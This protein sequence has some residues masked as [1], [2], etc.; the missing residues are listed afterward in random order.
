MN[1]SE[2][3]RIEH[4]INDECKLKLHMLRKDN[5]E[6]NRKFNVG[7]YVFNVTG[8]IKVEKIGYDIFLDN[9]EIIYY[10][11][12][13]KNIKGELTR[14]KNN[15]LISMFESHSLKILRKND[16]TNINNLYIK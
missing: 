10:G 13:Y 2:Y 11:Y 4:E 7:D 16:N 1:I 5:V 9:I 12:K 3:R 15:K 6:S 8:I 14:T